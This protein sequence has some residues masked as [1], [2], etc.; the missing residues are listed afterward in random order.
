MDGKIISSFRG[1]YAAF[2]NFYEKPNLV[3][4]QG[5]VF[6][7]TETT[8]QCQK[9][10]DENIKILAENMKPLEAKKTFGRSGLPNFPKFTLR[11]DWEGV[12]YGIMHDIV[13]AKFEQ[14]PSLKAL[15]LETNDIEL[16]EGN[17]WHDNC[18]GNCSCPRCTSIEGQNWLGKILM[19]VRF[20]LKD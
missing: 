16:V 14:N 20:E 8:F 6:T 11:S 5:L 19:E 10:L 13:K 2:S 1:K 18:W 7:N 15:L 12:K 4:Y 17:T 9:T 3:T